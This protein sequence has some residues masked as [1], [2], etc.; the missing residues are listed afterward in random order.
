MLLGSLAS[1]FYGVVRSTKD[2]DFVVE[3]SGKSIKDLMG[4]LGPEFRLQAQM[5][6]ESVTG[7][8]RRVID[9]SEIAYRIELFDLSADDHDRERFRRRKRVHLLQFDRQIFV[10]KVEDVI[11]TKLRWAH[12]AARGKDRDDVRNVL[13]VQQ[14]QVDW[15]YVYEWCNRHGTRELLDEIRQSIPPL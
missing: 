13:A 15:E 9:I 2:A 14:N 1:N 5:T 4:R 8:T 7:T 6:F 11:I 3:L 10:P 12:H